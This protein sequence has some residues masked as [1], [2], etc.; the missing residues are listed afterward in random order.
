MP[1]E[2]LAP[3]PTPEDPRNI[4]QRMAAAMANV[5]YVQKDKPKGLQYS[6]V[7]HDA[8][9]AKCRPALLAERVIYYPQNMEF[10]QNGNRTEVR[11]DL[12][13]V[14]IDAPEDFIL[15]PTLGYGL[16]NQDKGPGKAISYAVKYGLLKGLGLETGDDPDLDQ[17]TEHTPLAA[18]W[19]GPLGK[20]AL[21]EAA[22]ELREPIKNADTLDE[23][24]QVQ[25]DHFDVIDQIKTDMPLW[26]YGDDDSPGLAK[27]LAARR[28]ELAGLDR[29]D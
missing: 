25:V 21:L 18:V 29:K 10:S 17:T 20:T 27:T 7:S 16:D 13:F 5:A 26:Y 12:K 19:T 23:L 14:N 11:L 4:H 15:V 8:V 28:D 22:K 1:K 24:R 3:E 9:T 6:I 2:T